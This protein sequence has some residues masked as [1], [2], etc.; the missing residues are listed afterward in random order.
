MQWFCSGFPSNCW[1]T[2]CSKIGYHY[3]HSFLDVHFILHHCQ[4]CSTGAVLCRCRYPHTQSWR[5]LLQAGH[6]FIACGNQCLR[7]RV[8]IWFQKELHWFQKESCQTAW[9]Q[10]KTFE[11]Q[12]IPEISQLIALVS[13]GMALFKDLNWFQ[14]NCKTSI[15]PD[16]QSTEFLWI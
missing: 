3:K 5:T 2:A 11:I 8:L 6:V 10:Y 15:D 13:K 9:S 4:L 14:K 1:Y 12:R 16:R 7:P